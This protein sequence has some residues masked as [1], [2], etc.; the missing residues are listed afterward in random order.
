VTETTDADSQVNVLSA[1]LPKAAAITGT[2][3]LA[4]TTLVMVA[5]FLHHDYKDAEV[6]Y[7]VGRRVIEGRALLHLAHYRYPPAFAVMVA[8]LCLLPWPAFFFGWYALNVVLF[9]QCVR[10]TVRLTAATEARVVWLPALLVLCYAVDNLFLGQTNLLITVL[11][12][13]TMAELARGREW[14]AGVPLGASIAMKVFTFP[15]VAYLVYRGRWRALA[16]T[17]AVCAFCLLLLPAPVRGFQRNLYEVKDWGE[18][19]VAPYLGRGEAGDWGQHALDYGD[20]SL[21]AVL[22]RLLQ[23]VDAGVVARHERAIYVNLA[24]LT[25]AQV[26]AVLAA[27]VAL[28]AALFVFATG[29]RR[30]ADPGQEVVEFGM[31]AIALVLISALAWTY[32]YVMLLLPIAVGVDL[33]RARQPVP[34]RVFTRRVL[35]VALWV[36]GLAVLSLGS[37]QARAAGSLCWAVVLLYTVLAVACREMRR[38]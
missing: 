13:W 33:L 27:L 36:Q 9:V 35:T 37:T 11:L 22:H 17:L 4:M 8:P 1:G 2:A 28:L 29:W 38:A 30:P 24:D 31:S 34:L 15:W 5:K 3:L 26:N 7:D 21:Q 6:W 32:F 12:Y 10:F 25:E 19:V 20:Q 14:A 23:R 18:R 16:S